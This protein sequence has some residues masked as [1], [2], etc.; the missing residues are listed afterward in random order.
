M[1]GVV[2][3]RFYEELN[4]FLDKKYRKAAFDYHYTG[5]PS[6]KDAIESLGVP[7]TEVDLI[8]VSGASVDF[9]YQLKDHDEISVYPVFESIDI[10]GLQHLRKQALRDPKFILDVHLGKL[11]RYLRMVGFDCLYERSLSDEEIIRF[12]QA[13]QRIILTRDKGILK[14]GRVTRGLYVWSDDPREQFDEIVARLHLF[15]L[16]KPFSRCI[17]C[18]GAI[19][20]V[21]KESLM[22]RLKPLTKKHY[23]VFYRCTGCDRIYWEGSHF[24]RMMQ[25]INDY[26]RIHK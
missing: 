14:N 20:P 23:S 1:P 21:T 15:S 9:S 24:T 26:T 11:A 17:R 3:I 25:F 16:F 4:R 8:L 2:R 7:H 22:D 19:E 18:N 6:V 12:S 10:S 5:K 13:E